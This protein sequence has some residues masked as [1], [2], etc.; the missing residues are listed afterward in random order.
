MAGGELQMKVTT[1]AAKEK[2]TISV[3]KDLLQMVD[4]FVEESKDS[5][6]SRSAVFEQALHLWK[7]ALR[8]R[9][10]AAYYAENAEALKDDTW[11]AI[12]T[13]AAKHIW[14]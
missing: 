6:M 9:Y 3:D 7:Q 10:D 4:S 2:V 1:K 8:D 13:E 5:G 11:K 12:T 14:S